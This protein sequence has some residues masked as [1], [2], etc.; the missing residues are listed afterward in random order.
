[1]IKCNICG[2]SGIVIG[3]G[4]ITKK[5]NICEGSGKINKD[6]LKNDKPINIKSDIMKHIR[7]DHKKKLYL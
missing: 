7:D 5:C 1:M 2:G 4:M 3:L 6:K